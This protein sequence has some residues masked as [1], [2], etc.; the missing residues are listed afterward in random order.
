MFC[1]SVAAMGID[2]KK[3]KKRVDSRLIKTMILPGFADREGM[4]S[5]GKKRIKDNS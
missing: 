5:K 2:K 1:T 3:K 4:K